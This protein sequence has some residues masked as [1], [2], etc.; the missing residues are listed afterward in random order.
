MNLSDKRILVTGGR[1]FIGKHLIKR[2]TGLGAEVESFDIEDGQDITKESLV[3]KTIRKGYNFIYHLAAFSGNQKSLKNNDLCFR[4][5]TLATVS[6][7]NAIVKSSPKTK[8]IISSSRL[9]YGSPMYLPVD[10]KHPT[11]PTSPYGLSK[12]LASQM[13]E[14]FLKTGNLNYTIFRT[15]NVYGPHKDSRF[16]GFNVINYF[17]DLA[18]KNDTLKIFGKGDQLRDYLYIDDLI[19]AFLL[20]TEQKADHQIYNLGYGRKISLIE[21]ARLI[22]SAVGGGRVSRIEW[23]ND[24]KSLETGSYV[25]NIH[26]IERELG[27][28]PKTSF[29]DGI[30]KTINSS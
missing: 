12:L 8:I 4:I 23:P 30:K 29:L 25:T 24:W 17:I 10:E 2:L 22:V 5:N 9:E 1:G 28:K 6:M 3:K 15:S 18:K 7:L 26:K 13:A 20:A 21:M 27:F 14:V 11:L 16:L 19:D